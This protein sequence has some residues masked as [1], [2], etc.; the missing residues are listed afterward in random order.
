MSSTSDAH[1]IAVAE[2]ISK[3]LSGK[4]H[5]PGFGKGWKASRPKVSTKYADVLIEGPGV[6]L[7]LEVKMGQNDFLMNPRF[8]Y[9]ERGGKPVTQG[10]GPGFPF[11]NGWYVAYDVNDITNKLENSNSTVACGVL[12]EKISKDPNIKL[13]IQTIKEWLQYG[14]KNRANRQAYWKKQINNYFHMSSAGGV[15][16][17]NEN[18]MVNVQDM[19]GFVY[20][21]TRNP[22]KKW[23][24]SLKE[25]TVLGGQRYQEPK[26]INGS[27]NFA[28]QN[29]C[30]KIINVPD[31]VA[32]HYAHK[33]DGGAYYMQAGHDFYIMPIMGRSGSKGEDPLH[34]NKK[35][36]AQDSS[37]KSIPKF[38]CKSPESAITVRLSN[39]S[40]FHEFMTEIKMKD[41]THSDYSAIP[42]KGKIDPF[43]G[44]VWDHTVP[45]TEPK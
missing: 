18:G 37:S 13:W 24:K 23:R 26:R 28:N 25:D 20:D 4:G 7:W 1:E 11:F 8:G 42:Y 9:Q 19:K 2:F 15:Q 12:L 33:A 35:L 17:K 39:R 30:A 3:S 45:I 5:L 41:W 22:D 43:T 36:K 14:G 29:L 31:L 32:T 27:L 38:G 10:K 21:L 6:H 44:K 34:L 40:S 16:R